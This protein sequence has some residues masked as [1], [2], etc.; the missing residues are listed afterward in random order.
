MVTHFKLF[1]AAPNVR[2]E[3]WSRIEGIAQKMGRS[4]IRPYPLGHAFSAFRN[5]PTSAN[6]ASIVSRALPSRRLFT[7]M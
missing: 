4:G 2:L 7:K 5:D 1:G 3:R 6:I